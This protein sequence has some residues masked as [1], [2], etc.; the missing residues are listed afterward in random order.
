MARY[1]MAPRPGQSSV[2][3]A[4]SPKKASASCKQREEGGCNIDLSG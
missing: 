2:K 3:L 4:A 1:P